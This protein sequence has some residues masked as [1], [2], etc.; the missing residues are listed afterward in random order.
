MGPHFR[1][2]AGAHEIPLYAAQLRILFNRCYGTPPWGATQYEI[3]ESVQYLRQPTAGW[4]AAVALG[5][6]GSVLGLAYGADGTAM[7]ANLVLVDPKSA[8]ELP[9]PLFEL[10]HLAVAPGICSAEVGRHLHD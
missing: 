4:R 10:R 9:T 6:E 8:A 5:D 2:L 1:T 3:E 7:R